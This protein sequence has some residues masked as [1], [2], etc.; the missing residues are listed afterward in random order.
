MNKLE[1]TLVGQAREY[2]SAVLDYY[3]AQQTGADSELLE[4]DY[5][6]DHGA[7]CAL[8]NLVQLD[9]SGLTVEAIDAL[10]EI[11]AE[12]LAAVPSFDR[13]SGTHESPPL[14][15]PVRWQDGRVGMVDVSQAESVRI[16]GDVAPRAEDAEVAA[17]QH[18][19]SLGFNVV[20]VTQEHPGTGK[21]TN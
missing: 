14:N 6:G 16:L 18:A 17:H 1:I 13:G 2:L 5:L 7:L 3:T 21:Q 11:E 4:N 10:R 8:L 15:V 20:T 19:R 12:H 9:D